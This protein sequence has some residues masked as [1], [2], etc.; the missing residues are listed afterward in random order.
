VLKLVALFASFVI[1]LVAASVSMYGEP[2]G[3]FI[4]KYFPCQ[5]A[6]IRLVL[7]GL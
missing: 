1:L 3:T 4:G 6:L 2:K 7:L 5:I